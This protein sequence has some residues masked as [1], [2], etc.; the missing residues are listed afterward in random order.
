MQQP[1]EKSPEFAHSASADLISA[2]RK[3]VRRS[4]F[5]LVVG[6][7]ALIVFIVV[8]G[9]VRNRGWALTYANE[10]A[11]QLQA[12]VAADRLLPS[13]LSAA[14][15]GGQALKKMYRFEHLTPDQALALRDARRAI[16]VAQTIPVARRLAPDGRAVVLYEQGVFRAEWMTLA[17]FDDLWATQQVRGAHGIEDL[18]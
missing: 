2:R 17:R 11:Q 18:P 7:L 1:A 14:L 15:A 4:V 8:T 9:D 16:I 5:F 3:G 12:R 10:Y 6:L 13:D